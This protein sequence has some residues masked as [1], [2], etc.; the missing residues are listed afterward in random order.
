MINVKNLNRPKLGLI[1][2]VTIISIL[3][4][5]S[6][7]S[8]ASNPEAK[9]AIIEWCHGNIAY[10]FERE[11]PKELNFST[12]CNCLAAEWEP[13]LNNSQRDL[14]VTYRDELSRGDLPDDKEPIFEQILEYAPASAKT[15]G[16][17]IG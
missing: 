11:G 17:D 5:V 14:L 1:P 13:N 3:I 2:S 12:F 9:N 4:S 8:K 15:C 7:C 6:G 10:E 16:W